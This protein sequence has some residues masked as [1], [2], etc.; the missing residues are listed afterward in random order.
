MMIHILVVEDEPWW[1]RILKGKLEDKGFEVDLACGYEDGKEKAIKG[2]DKYQLL[3][4]DLGLNMNSKKLE[5]IELIRELQDEYCEFPCVVFSVH[6]DYETRV[7]ANKFGA[8]TVISKPTKQEP[9][10]FDE[11][12][13][14]INTQIARYEPP[15][16]TR[17]PVKVDEEDTRTILVSGQKVRLSPSEYSV[18]SYLFRKNNA[19]IDDLIEH[20][21]D[22]DPTALENK[23]YRLRKNTVEAFIKIIRKKI[24]NKLGDDTDP[25]PCH[26]HRYQLTWPLNR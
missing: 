15:T 20:V 9:R 12:Y 5:G 22:I 1:R 3:V 18:F 11:L 14:A 19:P 13:A 23:E 17:G 8:V 2:K 10:F 4:M 24:K 25:I 6:Q 21:Y 26:N 16:D 7:M